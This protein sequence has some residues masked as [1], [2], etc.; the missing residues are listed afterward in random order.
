MYATNIGRLSIWLSIA[1]VV[2]GARL[3]APATA[4]ADTEVAK[5]ATVPLFEG[6]GSHTRKVS[7]LSE[8]A[9]RYF[10]QGLTWAYAFNH[11]EAI[12][13]FEEA[14]RLDPASPMPQWGI[15]L[16]NGPHINNPAMDEPHSRAAWDALQKA[17]SLKGNATPTEKAL[18]EALTA[19]YADPAAGKLP[20]T[21]DERAPFDRAYAA[22]MK[23]VY[24]ANEDDTDVA[25]LYAESMMD[26]L[27][28]NLFD[29]N[30]QPR[31]ETPEIVAVLEHALA[32]DPKHPG[33]T[34]L[35][36]HALEA[37]PTPEKAFAAA[38]VLRTQVPISGHL[39]HM[40]GHI[41]VRVGRWDRAIEQNRAALKAD[42]AYRK[43]SP[44]QGFYRIYMAHNDQFLAWAAMM[45]GR[46][47]DAITHAKA[48]LT[49]MPADF[50]KEWAA[51]IDGYTPIDIDALIRF[52][53]WDDLLALEKPPAYLPLRTAMW[54]FG[55]GTAL[56][57]EGDTKNANAE[58]A[59]MRRIISSLPKEQIMTLN[60]AQ[61]VLSIG[62]HVLAGEI[63]YRGGSIDDAIAEL[64]KA[65]Q[66]EDSLRYIEPP[67]WIQ[68]ARHSLGAVLLAADRV[69]EAEA[70]YR[71]DLKRWPENGWALHGLADALERKKSPEAA[72]VKARF[73]KAWARA[74]TPIHATCL[75]IEK[76][77]KTGT[78]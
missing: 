55:R 18:I 59:S 54:H 64:T 14:A 7:T 24:E 67:D 17:L 10:D 57:A 8:Q 50:V 51:A 53:R 13:S 78:D 31:P 9:Q 46:S 20:L 47:A 12:R 73:E 32:I 22:A 77:A 44:H 76:D 49:T 33:A 69:D 75:C 43:I 27:P 40:P 56:A 35:Y 29:T 30:G 45:E 72:A 39:V 4:H 61:Q 71:A 38:D 37:S 41:D 34:H 36:V 68:P 6:L 42:A 52:G 16:C 23:K 2:L 65:V 74:D 28:W 26:L 5:G 21:F 11:D 60:P 19:R 62:E 1:A 58:L 63:A 66:I 70:V 48:M 15:A 25:T 3:V